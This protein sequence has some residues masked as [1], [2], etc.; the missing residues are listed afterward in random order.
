VSQSDQPVG[1]HNQEQPVPPPNP[2]AAP[3][4]PVIPPPDN[5]EAPRTAPPERPPDAERKMKLD[6]AQKNFEKTLCTLE[7]EEK[8]AEFEEES[9]AADLSQTLTRQKIP[10]IELED[11]LV[12]EWCHE[13]REGRLLILESWD[14]LV[15]HAAAQ[16]VAFHSSWSDMDCR[17]VEVT[18]ASGTFKLKTI[19]ERAASPQKRNRLIVIYEVMPQGVS[20]LHSNWYAHPS[21]ATFRELLKKNRIHLLVV[22]FSGL[23]R[24][25]RLDYDRNI[26]FT[27][28]KQNVDFVLPRL[29][30]CFVAKALAYQEKLLEQQ[31]KEGLWSSDDGELQEELVAAIRRGTL[32][33][34]I[35]SSDERRTQISLQ[36]KVNPVAFL[37]SATPLER[38]L[39]WLAT[40][41]PSLPARDFEHALKVVLE[42]PK[43]GT[44]EYQK[45]WN[46]WEADST[47][48]LDKCH[49]SIQESGVQSP[50]IG[51]QRSSLE[52][53]YQRAFV[54][55]F[56]FQ[57]EQFFERIETAHFVLSNRDSL[58][59][60]ATGLLAQRCL[61]ESD[62]FT[63]TLLHRTISLL[64]ESPETA[65][66]PDALMERLSVDQRRAIRRALAYLLQRLMKDGGAEAA[67]RMLVTLAGAG[68]LQTAFEVFK[69]SWPEDFSSEN[70]L[71]VLAPFLLRGKGPLPERARRL[72]LKIVS[73]KPERM[74]EI[75]SIL[76]N[77]LPEAAA[78]EWLAFAC[79][80]HIEGI[81]SLETDPVLQSALEDKQAEDG[82]L[83]KFFD[84]LASPPFDD[85]VAK[86]KP[87]DPD[88]EKLDLL[89]YWLLPYRELSRLD[90]E[91]VLIY[92]G[93]QLNARNLIWI[94]IQ[95]LPQQYKLEPVDLFRAILV[96]NWAYEAESRGEK[97]DF[98][99]ECLVASLRQKNPQRLMAIKVA[100]GALVEMLGEALSTSLASPSTTKAA[101]TVKISMSE[102]WKGLRRSLLAMRGRLADQ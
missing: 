79:E 4:D 51:F 96:G 37:P 89:S 12:T 81:R 23:L 53:V 43:P 39:V 40:F 85:V 38:A 15:L 59:R 90:V 11:S 36:E 54:D 64:A 47:T 66:S 91:P 74:G 102:R 86:R 1:E 97:L 84:Y 98:T 33:K 26:L 32:E 100:A 46:T 22:V 83:R 21:L 95:N 25:R 71:R 29:K 44:D 5:R 17:Y 101:Y 78:V 63:S 62:D 28:C 9:D 61:R 14:S 73:R 7:E 68:G 75:C 77:I 69:E 2:S 31:K 72:L 99:M 70:L 49:L 41:L 88:L 34:E 42:G 56:R 94:K 35:E 10:G 76:P 6:E 20:I 30:A 67:T 82:Y 93:A 87:F 27:E 19:A 60:A 50:R 16:S 92:L 45:L 3:P 48:V 57:Y 18:E 52:A 24:K 58:R 80:R 8:E 65:A 55:K 13:L